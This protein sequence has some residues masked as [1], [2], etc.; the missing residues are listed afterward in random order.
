MEHLHTNTHTHTH[1]HTHDL[2]NPGKRVYFN[3]QDVC[4]AF[5]FI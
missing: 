1:T 4:V 3:L 2:L 5:S